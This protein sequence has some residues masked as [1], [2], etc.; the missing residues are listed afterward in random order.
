MSKEW[1][2]LLTFSYI[3]IFIFIYVFIYSVRI[4]GNVCTI[5]NEEF[6]D[7]DIKRIII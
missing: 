4:N 5:G 7:S 2:V 6:E 3:Y 1:S